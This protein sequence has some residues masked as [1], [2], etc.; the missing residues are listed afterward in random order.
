M[1]VLNSTPRTWVAS[2]VVTATH[3]NTEV[4]DAL[5][6]LQ[7]AWTAWTPTI[8]AETGTFT[9]VSTITAR[10]QRFGK[11]CVWTANFQITT[12]GTAANGF[13]FT[14]P[15]TPHAGSTYVGAGRESASTG[16]ALHAIHLGAGVAQV[17]RYDNASVIAAGRTLNL[18]GTFEIA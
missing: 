12:V 4:R 13:R 7:A 8:T 3:M 11:T 5:T 1:A 18:G 15:V 6:N 16:V 17:N 14:L 10:Y 2:E 9:S